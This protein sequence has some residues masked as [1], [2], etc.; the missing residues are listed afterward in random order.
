MIH[1]LTK[2]LSKKKKNTKS[3]LSDFLLSAVQIYSWDWR[4]YLCANLII[5]IK[6]SQK[7]FTKAIIFN[8]LLRPLG[9][10]K[11]NI[12]TTLTVAV[13]SASTLFHLKLSHFSKSCSWKRQSWISNLWLFDF[14]AGI[15]PLHLVPFEE[16]SLTI[17]H[18]SLDHSL[19][20]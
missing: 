1:S 16:F 19:E 12:A 14:S 13:L 20:L 18:G 10:Q 8:A 5:K 11:Q 2:R 4:I 7:M 3:R 6:I 17:S 9:I 15:F